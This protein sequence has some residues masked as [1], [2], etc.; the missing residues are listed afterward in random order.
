MLQSNGCT[1]VVFRDC[2]ALLRGMTRRYAEVVR[3]SG[4]V[5]QTPILPR[6]A[7]QSVHKRG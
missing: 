1:L 4:R 5:R 3:K 2:R 6:S 7:P